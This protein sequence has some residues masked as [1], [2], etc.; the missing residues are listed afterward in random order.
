MFNLNGD[1]VFN[2]NETNF[3]SEDVYSPLIYQDL[4]I[5]YEY[6]KNYI[7]DSDII[8]DDTI[9]YLISEG[10]AKVSEKISI[11]NKI[12]NKLNKIKD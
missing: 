1:K 6:T 5:L 11:F 2:L 7:M 9:F 4:Y 12:N 10:S 8:D 3:S